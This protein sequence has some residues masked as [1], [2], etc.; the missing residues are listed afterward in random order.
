MQLAHNLNRTLLKLNIRKYKLKL[1]K[2][3]TSYASTKKKVFV[4]TLEYIKQSK[5]KGNKTLWHENDWGE[6]YRCPLSSS[7]EQLSVKNGTDWLPKP[8]CER[9]CLTE[10]L[11][12]MFIWKVASLRFLLQLLLRMQTH[13]ETLN[14]HGED[15]INA[16]FSDYYLLSF[17][18]LLLL[19]GNVDNAVVLWPYRFTAALVSDNDTD[20]VHT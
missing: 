12:Q 3:I 1:I 19:F 16:Y 20:K 2:F 18:S 17:Q 4:F 15:K 11:T 5:S 6:S 10:K 8:W 9:C 14:R 13:T 7:T